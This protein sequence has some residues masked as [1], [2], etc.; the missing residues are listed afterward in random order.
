MIVMII[1]GFLIVSGLIGLAFTIIIYF[2]LEQFA[3]AGYPT[4]IFLFSGVGSIIEIVI[5]VV[6]LIIGFAKKKNKGEQALQIYNQGIPAKARVTF[7]DKDYSYLVN[8][9][10]IY[11]VVEFVFT[12]HMGRQHTARKKQVE[13]DLVIRTNITVGSE[14]D[15]KYMSADPDKN[16]LMIKD[17]TAPAV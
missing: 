8:E 10:P 11:S 9:K 17:P 16:V 12:D 15:I 14:V 6:L 5:G 3:P 13:S 2:V 7:V 1:G 4:W